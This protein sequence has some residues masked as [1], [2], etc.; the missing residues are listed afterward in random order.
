MPELKHP[1]FG[2]FKINDDGFFEVPNEY[3][4]RILAGTPNIWT[5][6]P[7]QKKKGEMTGAEYSAMSYG[8]LTK[9][10]YSRGVKHAHGMSRVN[11]VKALTSLDKEGKTA[12]VPEPKKTE[13]A[14]VEES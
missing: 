8:E 7:S 5:E 10:A 14:K 4:D 13:K 1:K 11:I 3:A 12:D 6:K 9:Y 2:K